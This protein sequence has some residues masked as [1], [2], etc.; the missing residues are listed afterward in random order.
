MNTERQARQ[1]QIDRQLGHAG[2]AFGSRRLITEFLVPI[3][4]G[5][6]E[7]GAGERRTVEFADYALLDRLGRPLAIVE[8]KRSSRDPLE[9]ERQA[10]DYAEAIRQKSGSDP[11]VFLAN[12]NEIWFWHRKLYPPRKV[13]GF[14][15]EDDLLRLAHLDRFGTPLSGQMP[16]TRI[17]DRSYQIEAVK[18]IAEG[19]EHARRRF[20]M[21]LATGTG[22][23]RVA[24]ALIELLQRCER[25]QRVLFLADRRELVKQALGAFKEHLPGAPRA[26]IEG[27]SIDRDAQIHFATYPGMMSL[28]QQLSPGYYDLIVADESHRSIYSRYKSILDHFDAITLGLTAT[29]TDFLDHNTFDLF[30]CRDDSPSFYY[31]YDEAVR[32]HCLVPY[33]P[34]HVARTTFQV[35]GLQPGDLPEEVKQQVREQGIDPEQFS[36]EGSDLERCVTN[37]GTNDAIVR[38]FMDNAIKDAVGTLPAKSIIFAVSHKHA[39]E[40]YKSFNRLYP[41]LQRRG[42]ARV[43]DSQM[44][45]ADKT[46]DDFKNRD[47][48]RVAIS[49]DMLDTGIDVPPIRNLVFAKPVF[50]KVKFWQMLGRGTRPWTDPLNGLKKADFLVIDH[51]DN[52]DYFQVNKDGRAASVSEPLPTRLFRLRLEK[53]QILAGRSAT[54]PVAFTRKQLQDL[55]GTLPL[56][57]I[58]VAPH[59]DEICALA[60]TETPWRELTDERVAHLSQTIAPLLRFS[61]AGSYA[62]LQ[63]ENQ[64]EQLTLAH[65]RADAGEVQRLRVNISEN[66]ALLPTEI[67]E[68]RAHLATLTATRSDAF[69]AK[70][71]FTRIMEL[72]ET[73]AP[74]MRFRNRRPPGTMVRLSLPDAIQRRH[75]ILFGPSGEGAFAETYRAQV[76]ALV[77]DLAGDNPALQRLKKGQELTPDDYAALAAVLEGPDLFITED[78]LREAYGQPRAS[79]VDFLR[80]ILKVSMLPSREETIASAFDDW[81][82]EHPRL[83]ATQLMFIRTVRKAVLQ[84]ARVSSLDALRKPPFSAIGDPATLFPEAELNELFAL[85]DAIAA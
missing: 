24:V 70:L 58:N 52:F 71:S 48:P 40:I 50:S 5:I 45:R 34:V 22:K 3:P 14:F 67:P 64:T 56:E 28:Y 78:R 30:D 15:T 16:S 33:R 21:V 39:L 9:G 10:A 12:G 36:F 32:D 42:L 81:V 20:L 63:F 68:V 23:T 59:A 76:E 47:F 85:V 54:A 29:P 2:W 37:S 27:G 31:G 13:S 73:F 43:I 80:H 44:E 4:S 72:Q 26:W 82:R 6:R 41:D 60:A 25:I 61:V 65:L 18:T 62:E 55:V 69:W 19:I 74:L 66:L 53:L 1:E 8:A 17:I 75:W 57:N 83:S 51:W 38:E 84:K 35:E 49:V 7:P 11:F 77:K 79:L 46:L